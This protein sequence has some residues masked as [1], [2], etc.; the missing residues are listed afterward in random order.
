MDSV[1]R[2]YSEHAVRRAARGAARTGVV[3]VVQRTS[4]D[5]RLNPHLHVLPAMTLFAG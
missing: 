5:L 2:F 4:I 1:E 3:M